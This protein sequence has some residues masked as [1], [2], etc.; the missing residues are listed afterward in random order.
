MKKIIF[1][2]DVLIDYL[3]R[4]PSVVSAIDE[5]VV[6]GAMMA[7]TPVTETEIFQ[8]VRTNEME[9]TQRAL[10]TFECLVLNRAIGRHAG[11]YVK[12]Y[13]KSHGVELPDALIAASAHI[14]KFA[15]CTFNW[16]HYPMQDVEH[17]R[18][19]R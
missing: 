9:K 11:L 18:M 3:R 14:H 16:K 8:G 13:G 7:I 10:E 17:Y 19:N 12:K 4:V 6:T 15:L 2:S 1:D 5:L